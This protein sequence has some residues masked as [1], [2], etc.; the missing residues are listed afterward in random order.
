MPLDATLR[1]REEEEYCYESQLL[2]IGYK[3]K[4]GTECKGGVDLS[5]T[6]VACDQW[7]NFRLRL[8]ALAAEWKSLASALFLVY[9]AYRVVR[10]IVEKLRAR[11]DEARAQREL[12]NMKNS[13]YHNF[14]FEGQDNDLF[15]L[16][17]GSETN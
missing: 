16:D 6:V 13:Q 7:K 1:E 8:R 12:I 14:E 10:K 3:R 5:P 17:A 9:L 2:S 15:D 4:I 11:E